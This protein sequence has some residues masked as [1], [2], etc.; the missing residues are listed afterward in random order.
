MHVYFIIYSLVLKEKSSTLRS[1]KY[2]LDQRLV[3][4]LF[5]NFNQYYNRRCTAGFQVKWSDA[6]MYLAFN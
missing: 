4:I 6:F 3:I 2:F 5:F 1:I